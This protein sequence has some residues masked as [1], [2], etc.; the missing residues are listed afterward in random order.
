[1]KK[2]LFILLPFMF[3]S[4]AFS[5]IF[6]KGEIVDEADKTKLSNATIMLLQSRDSIL[7]DFTRSGE[8][9]K[10]QLI[11]PDTGSYLLIISYPKFGDYYTPIDGNK[12]NEDIGQIGLT[13][14]TNLLEEVL[15][16]GKIPIVIKGDTVEYDA[17]SFT[18]EKNAKV[19]D[20]LKV[21]PGISVDASGKITA[22]GKTVEK[23]LVDG[24]EFFG[25]D[26]VLVTR[27]IRS[28]MVDKVQVYEKKSDQAERTGVDDGQR[29]Q[30][31]NLKLKEEAKH[32]IFGK[33]EAGAA[34][35]KFYLGQMMTNYFKKSLRL[36]AYLIAS[37]NGKTDLSGDEASSIGNEDRGGQGQFS[38]EGR[39]EVL[40]TGVQ[41]ADKSNNGRHY[42]HVGYK[43]NDAN[44]D[45][46]RSVFT[47]NSLRDTALITNND[48]RINSHNNKQ[49]MYLK[50]EAKFDSLTTLTVWAGASR[51][52][53]EYN[54][55]SVSKT[56]NQFN[57]KINDNERNSSNTNRNE[58]LNASTLFTRKFGK[59]GRSLS[60]YYGTNTSDA[61]SDQ[62]IYALTNYFRNN[63]LLPDSLDQNKVSENTSINHDAKVTYSEP[64]LKN[65]VVS[66]EYGITNNFNQNKLESFNKNEQTQAYDIL[67][68]EFSNDYEYNT[69]INRYNVAFNYKVGDALNFNFSNAF[70]DNELSQKNNYDNSEL[71]RTFFTYSPR[72]NT[73]YSITKNSM[74]SLN[75]RGDNTLP[76][77]TQIQPLRSNEDPL[78]EYLGNE[79]LKNSYTH[80]MDINY[81]ASKLLQGTFYGFGANA[82]STEDAL[83]QNVMTDSLGK[84]TYIWDNL[85]IRNNQSLSFYSWYSTFLHKKYQIRLGVNPGITINK[86]YNY[87]NS[88]LA[89]SLNQTYNM[90]LSL[91]RSTTKGFDFDVAV[92][93]GYTVRSTDLNTQADSKGFT[94]SSNN[95]LKYY[96]PMKFVLQA[97]LNYIY[98]APTEVYSQK[99]E[100]LLLNP[101]ISKKFLKD[102]TLMLTLAAN[103]ILNQNIGFS[104]VQSGAQLTE[105]RYNTIGRYFMLKVSWDIN[106][107]F[108]Q[109]N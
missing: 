68:D 48:S 84:N 5:Q 81:W 38:G 67:D 46:N 108:V 32:G 23:V 89:A 73:R 85:S 76:N 57:D 53:S 13:S 10:F 19:E 104:R 8:N 109:A 78:N 44:N 18:V 72:M 35:D 27:N 28:D 29:S 107:M 63:E 25:D 66:F 100:R 47:Q 102:E 39:P 3:S 7:V 70:N 74:L 31:I 43:L 17:S 21:L 36:S 96:L 56:M 82:S 49:D 33:I 64:I 91:Q 95:A 6:I 86:N 97:D 80:N 87:V 40:N 2:I 88:L 22:Q 83:I 26:P 103:D 55:S 42:W 59:E 16:T 69:F 54:S 11:K 37:N 51:T 12:Q 15:V 98:E 105:R 1:M 45:I 30:T 50:Y 65:L 34:T 75:Y 41:Y 79:E 106:K 9:G 99:F 61:E 92:V 20:L 90:G 52:K 101:S 62:Y 71:S 60:F 93:P 94:F 77:L 24:E 58:S 4:S 14:V